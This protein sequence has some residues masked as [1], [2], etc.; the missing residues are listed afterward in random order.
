VTAALA[1]AAATWGIA[2]A[3]SPLLQIRAIVRERSARGVSIGYFCVLIVGFSLWL[4]Y[5]IAIRNVALISSNV[6][7]VVVSTLTTVVA[8]AY[9]RPRHEPAPAE[10]LAERPSLHGP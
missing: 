8:L 6:V 10:G 5:G 1:V 9:R 3:L 4:A 2:M 7:A